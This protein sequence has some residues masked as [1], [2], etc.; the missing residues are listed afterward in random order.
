MMDGI[1][2]VL[3]HK[4]IIAPGKKAVLALKKKWYLINLWTSHLRCMRI[5]FNLKIFTFLYLK[6][7]N[8]KDSTLLSLY[9]HN[10]ALLLDPPPTPEYFFLRLF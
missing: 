6:I 7:F 10:I 2:L 4:P 1:A 3:S 9:T 8:I 5:F